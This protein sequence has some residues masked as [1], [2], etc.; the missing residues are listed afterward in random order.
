[1]FGV[2]FLEMVDKIIRIKAFTFLAHFNCFTMD[3]NS[4]GLELSQ[5]KMR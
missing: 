1:M 4:F 3:Q 5:S 2:Q